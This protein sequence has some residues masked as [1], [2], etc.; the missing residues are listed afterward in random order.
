MT[1]KETDNK[2]TDQAWAS[3]YTRIEQ[4]GLLPA[5]TTA[6]TLNLRA[7]IIKWSVAAMVLCI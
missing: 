4:D 3:L 6:G 5:E 7:T 2:I 1:W